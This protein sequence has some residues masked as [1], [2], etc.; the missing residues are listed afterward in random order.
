MCGAENGLFLIGFWDGTLVHVVDENGT[1]QRSFGSRIRSDTTP[2]VQAFLDRAGV[3]SACDDASHS[4]YL[5]ESGNDIVRAYA[6]DG[7]LRWESRLPDYGGYQAISSRGGMSVRFSRRITKSVVPFDDYL[8]VQAQ[9]RASVRTGPKSLREDY[10]NVHTFVLSRTTGQL[11]GETQRLPLLHFTGARRFVVEVSDP[12][13]AVY[14][15]K[16][17][18]K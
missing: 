15:A 3:T 18:R 17:A 5:A 16:L 4:V 6:M 12:F 2:V 14:P 10:G 1:T 13:P 7:A 8:L 9:D 11:V